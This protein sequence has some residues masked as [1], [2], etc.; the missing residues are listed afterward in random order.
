MT[1]ALVIPPPRLPAKLE[2]SAEWLADRDKLIG[3]E[4]ALAAIANQGEFTAAELLLR[5][6]TSTSNAA[7]TIRKALSDPFNRAAKDIKAMADGARAPLEAA[8]DRLKG[9]MSAYLR[10]EQLRQQQEME[11]Q[12]AARAKEEARLEAERLAA[13]AEA[14]RLQGEKAKAI[15]DENPFAVAEMQAAAE[16]AE[17]QAVDAAE[18][19]EVVAAAP[20]VPA[21]A[22]TRRVMTRAATVWR[23]EVTDATLVPREFCC[24]DERKIREHVNR[25]KDAAGIAGVRIWEEMDIR[26]R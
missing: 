14:R 4:S 22:T 26:S 6:I 10:A 3:Q 20:I 24:P 11:R 1:T 16:E 19:A 12:A 7:E 9:T 25:N 17:S 2:I 15:A 5:Q 21:T 18:Q 23:F 13:E 8:K